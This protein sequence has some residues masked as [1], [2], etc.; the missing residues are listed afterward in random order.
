MFNIE[1]TLTCQCSSAREFGGRELW[2][3]ASLGVEEGEGSFTRSDAGAEGSLRCRECSGLAKR[4]GA[5]CRLVDEARQRADSIWLA[6]GSYKW[7]LENP[8]PNLYS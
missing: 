2:D 4:R 3:R 6:V 8:I 1:K 7:V 5:L